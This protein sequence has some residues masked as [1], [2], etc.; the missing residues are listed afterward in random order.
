MKNLIFTAIAASM[1]CLASCGS[2]TE[3]PAASTDSA[4]VQTVPTVTIVADS[5]KADTTKK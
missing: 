2:A 5:A 3:Q 1:L 4:S